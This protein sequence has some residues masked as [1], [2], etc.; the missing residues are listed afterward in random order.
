MPDF[1]HAPAW[2]QD[3]APSARGAEISRGLSANEK[4]HAAGEHPSGNALCHPIVGVE[5]HRGGVRGQGL[6]E[7]KL[8]VYHIL[9]GHLFGMTLGYHGLQRFPVVHSTDSKYA[10]ATGNL[11]QPP[12]FADSQHSFTS[13]LV[14][15]QLF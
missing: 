5:E 11:L 7:F 15:R 14:S 12:N 13:S 9:I 1:F 2:L 4:P 8:T 3:S 6:A 10:L